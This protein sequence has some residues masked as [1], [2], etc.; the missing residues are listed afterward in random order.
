MK[1]EVSGKEL[2]DALLFV[3]KVVSSKSSLPVLMNVLLDAREDHLDIAGTDLDVWA[4]K[5]I[6]AKVWGPGAATVSPKLLGKFA[7]GESVLL[8]TVKNDKLRVGGGASLNAIP[9]DEFPLR[10][11]RKGG[12][13][14]VLTPRQAEQITTRALPAASVDEGRPAL[15]FVRLSSQGDGSLWAEAT[16][17]FRV[18]RLRLDVTENVTFSVLAHPK[19]LRTLSIGLRQATDLV[20]FTVEESCVRAELDEMVV[21]GNSQCEGKF[22]DD[23]T[24]HIPKGTDA[25]FRVRMPEF[26]EALSR[27][28]PFAKDSAMMVDLMVTDGAVDVSARSSEQGSYAESV[29]A[30]TVFGDGPHELGFSVNAGYLLDGLWAAC[31]KGYVWIGKNRDAGPAVLVA[32]GDGDFVYIT[33]PMHPTR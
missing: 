24:H 21:R 7:A 28:E 3:G 13:E 2:K 15:T 30:I 33:M 18:S 1:V 9:A 25:K 14:F 22:P 16:D 12:T 11:E 26:A 27:A 19:M 31:R 4:V 20:V 6:D 8:E 5:R 10:P 32:E 23:L 29:E 17:G